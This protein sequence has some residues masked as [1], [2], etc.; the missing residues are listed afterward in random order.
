MN[1]RQRKK[2][3]LLYTVIEELEAVRDPDRIDPTLRLVGA[4]WKT[5][6]DLRLAQVLAYIASGQ[7]GTGH[8]MDPFYMEED[9]LNARICRI[10]AND[11]Y[12]KSR[13][14]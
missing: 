1:K 2:G 3:K 6:P 4:L 5:M 14:E 13:K 10:F 8:N 11:A 12:A 7:G 9:E